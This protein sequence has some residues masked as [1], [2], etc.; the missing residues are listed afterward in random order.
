MSVQ[1]NSVQFKSDRGS[2]E[3]VSSDQEGLTELTDLRAALDR[4]PVSYRAREKM[5][6]RL[7]AAAIAVRNSYDK[8]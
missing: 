3:P 2:R 6:D 8:T 4:V 5:P 7:Y 1:F